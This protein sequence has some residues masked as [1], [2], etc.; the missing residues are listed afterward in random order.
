MSTVI[1]ISFSEGEPQKKKA[2]TEN[3][4]EDFSFSSLSRNQVTEASRQNVLEQNHMEG[5]YVNFCTRRV[6]LALCN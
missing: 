3:E 4:D 6:H 1:C 5:C 2:K